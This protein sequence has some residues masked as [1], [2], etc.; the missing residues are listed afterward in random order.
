ML[1]VM[2]VFDQSVVSLVSVWQCNWGIITESNR[3]K[4]IPNRPMF[5]HWKCLIRFEADLVHGTGLFLVTGISC[6]SH[7][8]KTTP[9]RLRTDSIPTP[10]RPTFDHRTLLL[11]HRSGVG[12]LMRLRYYICDTYTAEAWIVQAIISCYLWSRKPSHFFNIAFHRVPP[13]EAKS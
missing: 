6:Q 7:T 3:V 13:E 2:V 8:A 5:G 11:F 4:P 1:K 10:N 12:P 9:H